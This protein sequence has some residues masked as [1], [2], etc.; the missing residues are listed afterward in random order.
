MPDLAKYHPSVAGVLKW[1]EYGH[2]PEHLAQVSRALADV[3]FSMA[4]NN[5]PSAELT[6]GIRKLLE[7]KDCF[8]RAAIETKQKREY[9][10]TSQV[11]VTEKETTP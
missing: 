4:D 2:L 3:A 5:E 7:A 8:V 6:T 11:T 9:P 1:F 10:D